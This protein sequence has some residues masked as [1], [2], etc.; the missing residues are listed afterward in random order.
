MKQLDLF[1]LPVQEQVSSEENAL[2]LTSPTNSSDDKSIDCFQLQQ[3]VE[4]LS[5]IEDIANIEDY[6]YLIDFAG[7][8]GRIIDK[9]YYKKAISYSVEFK[10]G[11]CGVFYSHDIEAAEE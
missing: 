4:I 1:S 10:D 6:Y 11:K 3:V 8:R 5:P 7:K 9:H 2:D